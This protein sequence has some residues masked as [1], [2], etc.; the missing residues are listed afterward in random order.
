MALYDDFSE[1]FNYRKKHY[2][3]RETSRI[4]EV[5]EKNRGAR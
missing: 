1:E 5:H 4:V 2:G 3:V